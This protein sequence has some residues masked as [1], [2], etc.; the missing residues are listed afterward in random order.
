MNEVKGSTK[1][2]N[3][4]Q[5]TL[6]ALLPVSL[7]ATSPA[8]VAQLCNDMN[9]TDV[10]ASAG[11]NHVYTWPPTA[12]SAT[13]G[14]A[15]AADV[16]GDGWLDLYAVQGD[17]GPN[18]LYINDQNG[19]FTEEAA[20][21]GAQLNGLYGTAASA[22]DFDNDGDIDLGVSIY[23]GNSRV[24]IND[25]SGNFTSEIVLPFPLDERTFGSAW[26]DVD[27]DGYLELAIGMWVG[28]NGN[29]NAQGLYLYKNNAGVLQNYEFRTVPRNDSH[30]FAPRFADLNG[31]RLSDLHVVADYNETRVYMNIGGGMFIAGPGFGGLN[32]M[33][34]AIADYD[35][36]GDLDI[37]TTDIET[38]EGNTLWQNDGLGNFTNVSATAGIANGGWAWG[39]T[40][41]DLDLDADLDIYHVNGFPGDGGMWQD[42]PSLLFMN[43]DDG[44]FT[45]VAACANAEAAIGSMGRGVH[46]FDYDNDG[47]LD[48]FI[49]NNRYNPLGQAGQE[50]I[51]VLLRNDTPRNGKHWL[52]VMLDGTPPMHRDGIGSRVY[53][54]TGGTSQMHELHA[55]TN[56]L[57]QGAG[58]IAHFGLDT[59]S[60]A[61]EV[62]AEW[63]TGD[64]VVLTGVAGDQQI[65]I[66]SPTATVSTRTPFIGQQV[67]ATSNESAPV[68]WEI[69]GSTFADPVTTS[70]SS[71][72]TKE[73]KLLVYNP[74]M[75]QVVR[76]ELI[77]VDVDGSAGEPDITSPVNGSVLPNG[78]I[79]FSWNDNG[80]NADDWQ[81]LGGTSVGNNSLYDSGVLP[82]STTSAIVSG[83]PTDGSTI[84]VTL[85]WTDGG[86]ASEKNYTYIA[87]T[88]GGPAINDAP[89]V[90]APTGDQVFNQGDTVN[91]DASMAFDD[92]DADTLTYSASGLPANLSINPDNGVVTGDLTNDDAIAG[93]DYAVAITATETGTVELYSVD[94]SFTLTVNN[95]NDAP[96]VIAPTGN[97]AID[98]GTAVDID[99]AAAFEDID[100]DILTY[101]ASG[102]PASLS[103][104]PDTGSVTGTLMRADLVAGPD[105]AV[106]VTTREVGTA[107]AFTADDGF[108]MTVGA[109][110]TAAPVITLTGSATVTLTVGDTY[111]DEGATAVDDLDNDVTLDI[112]VDNPVDTGAA[113]TYT[114]SYNVS[115]SAGNAATEVTRTVTVNDPPVVTP[116]PR[117]TT[118]SG[119]GSISL[120][121]LLLLAGLL[122]WRRGKPGVFQPL[123]AD[124]KAR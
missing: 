73:L 106:I 102:L 98:E 71:G 100:G 59:A 2:I 30:I 22:A 81:L 76:Q 103:I 95:T 84:Y 46:M 63:V 90:I 3:R 37:F 64:A 89:T 107:N 87:P 114:V 13:P 104:N 9:F 68:E 49:V 44:T 82:V 79:T 60:V 94:D 88:G 119:G 85:R 109:V 40:F 91:L 27:N 115:D 38:N 35:K 58:H 14:G 6:L 47:D 23:Y 45:D 39:G 77:R 11:I 15:T 62:R 65:S 24:L 123:T 122:L 117:T 50:G 92:A 111:V 32:D 31:D 21:R 70:F 12:N 4:L 20:A 75:T 25:G 33:G 52:K 1:T 105:Y 69:G 78:D 74:S 66:P 51:P 43:N 72:G 41:G 8:A 97:Q 57:S 118:S 99:A 54:Q 120:A 28:R 29:H 96:T 48:I 5:T 116:P 86:N 34:H 67:T 101:S 53:V 80:A 7:L 61:D 124:E 18:L 36:D 17:G 56:F 26:G 93:P 112:E 108:T 83:L 10:T 42:N 110:D 121:F 19:G 55:S 113:G 16:N